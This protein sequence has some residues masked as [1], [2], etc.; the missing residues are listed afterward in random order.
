ML[1]FRA[2]REYQRRL[3]DLRAE[4]EEAERFHDEGRSARLRGE[5]DFLGRELARALGLGGR[6][7]RAQSSSERARLNVTR[8]IQAAR[9]KIRDAC[10]PLGRHLDST[11]RT[12]TFCSYVPDPSAPIPWEL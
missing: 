5:I 12:G 2:R 11:V 7:R 4:L 6:S 10:P 1:D 9:R 8:T 3:E